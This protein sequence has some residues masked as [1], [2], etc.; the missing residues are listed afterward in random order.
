[1]IPTASIQ[2]NSSSSKNESETVI[3]VVA[4]GALRDMTFTSALDKTENKTIN[5]NKGNRIESYSS[6]VPNN[7]STDS[8]SRIAAVQE[9]LKSS[10]LQQAKLSES[11]ASS[12]R[13]LLAP[14]PGL[15]TESTSGTNGSS[16]SH[17]MVPLMNVNEKDL[18]KPHMTEHTN[19]TTLINS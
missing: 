17:D 10:D 18:L 14:Q 2:N 15:Q 19:V 8:S 11:N 16:S 5:F 1:M 7:A 3:P 12:L 6:G 13:P 9:Q 4:T